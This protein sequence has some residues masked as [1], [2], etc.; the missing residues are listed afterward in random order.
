MDCRLP[1]GS[2]GTRGDFRRRYSRCRAVLPLVESRM[3]GSETLR[4]ARMADARCNGISVTVSPERSQSW[5]RRLAQLKVMLGVH[6]TTQSPAS[7]PSTSL[8][9]RHRAPKSGA[10]RA[11]ACRPRLRLHLPLEERSSVSQHIG[12]MGRGACW[13]NSPAPEPPHGGTL[14]VTNVVI[15][16]FPVLENIAVNRRLLGVNR[17]LN[18]TWRARFYSPHA[19]HSLL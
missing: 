3:S 13:D 2:D 11:T 12:P 16:T 5:T 19:P 17:R 6:C 4:R 9:E 15:P 1:Y 18:G 8:L 10:L 7:R 14:R